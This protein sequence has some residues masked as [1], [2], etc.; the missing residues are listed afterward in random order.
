LETSD[1]DGVR[2]L[3]KA[4][5][6]ACKHYKRDGEYTQCINFLLE[7][8]ANPEVRIIDGQTSLQMLSS[9]ASKYDCRELLRKLKKSRYED[10]IKCAG[11]DRQKYRE[12]VDWAAKRVL[13]PELKK[14]MTLDA[15]SVLF[16]EDSIR[17]RQIDYYLHRATIG[18]AVKAGV[19]K[20]HST[21]PYKEMVEYLLE[22]GADPKAKSFY[23]DQ[24]IVDKIKQWEFELPY[25]TTKDEVLQFFALYK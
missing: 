16:E 3:D 6:L 2:P 12:C 8:R 11:A 1:T 24:S 22:A 20:S 9:R 14:L 21:K 10:V 15:G 19:F 18:W 25:T 7:H 23:Y 4:L 13:L 5:A 17:Y